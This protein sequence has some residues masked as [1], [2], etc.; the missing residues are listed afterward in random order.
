MEILR[1]LADPQES[2]RVS[3]QVIVDDNYHCFVFF[4]FC[5]RD[6]WSDSGRDR[7]LFLKGRGEP[8]LA[9]ASRML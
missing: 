8:Q 4:P 3:Y 1:A 7:L 9:W 5:Q 2:R 6:I